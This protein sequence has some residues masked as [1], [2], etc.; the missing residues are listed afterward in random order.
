MARF[1]SNFF[2]NVGAYRTL[3]PSPFLRP[4]TAQT[5][6][7]IMSCHILE[8]AHIHPANCETIAGSHADIVREVFV[9]GVLVGGAA[10]LQRVIASGE[11]P[12]RLA[13]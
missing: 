13:G 6:E 12:R 10:E 11:F 4:P 8:A 5:P 9:K 1:G 3:K 7:L 2:Q